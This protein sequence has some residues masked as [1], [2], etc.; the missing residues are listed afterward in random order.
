M[1]LFDLASGGSEGKSS[2]YSAK[3]KQVAEQTNKACKDGSDC[4]NN[5]E[6]TQDV[7]ISGDSKQCRWFLYCRTGSHSGQHRLHTFNMH[8]QFSSNTECF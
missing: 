8:K 6:Q 7:G 2:L 1:Q 3:V 5:L 4:Q